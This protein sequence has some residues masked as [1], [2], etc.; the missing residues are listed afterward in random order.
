MRRRK[1]KSARREKKDRQQKE[2]IKVVVMPTSYN[3][4]S[5]HRAQSRPR[6]VAHW[7]V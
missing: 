4:K 5:K 2:Y 6:P 1:T 7:P 3:S